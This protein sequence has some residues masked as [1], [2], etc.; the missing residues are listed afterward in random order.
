[1]PHNLDR[2]LLLQYS[3]WIY[4][5]AMDGWSDSHK[6]ISTNHIYH[7]RTYQVM[8][9]KPFLALLVV[10]ICVVGLFVAMYWNVLVLTCIIRYGTPNPK[11]NLFWQL[12][13]QYA[14]DIFTERFQFSVTF[15]RIEMLLDAPIVFMICF[16]MTISHRPF[17]IYVKLRVTH[18]PGMPGAFY[19]PPRVSDPDTYHGTCVTHVPWC[20]LWSLTSGFLW[21]R[22]QGKRSRHYRRMRNVQFYVSGKRSV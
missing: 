15:Q 22:W 18:A 17:T 2:N 20:M 19:P 12:L 8:I 13:R 21:S 1:M 9:T 7:V 14:I 3:F 11:I 6:N 16:V 5:E 4:N 10:T